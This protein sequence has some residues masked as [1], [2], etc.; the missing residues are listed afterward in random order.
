MTNCLFFVAIRKNIPYNRSEIILTRNCEGTEQLRIC[1][2]R[3][4]GVVADVHRNNRKITGIY[5]EKSDCISGGGRNEKTIYGRWISVAFR[6]RTL[7]ADARRK[8][9]SDQK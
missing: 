2:I 3:A 6:E 4:R 7:E 5:R 1:P 8:I 9:C